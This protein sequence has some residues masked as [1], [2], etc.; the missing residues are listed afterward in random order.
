MSA[1]ALSDPLDAARAVLRSGDAQAA[2]SLLET[3][4]AEP[5]LAATVHHAEVSIELG[6]ILEQAGDY[7]EAMARFVQGHDIA[8]RHDHPAL[9]AR[10]LRGMA[11]VDHAM[12]DLQHAL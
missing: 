5:D 6:D 11:R 12:G 4:L 7:A 9:K 3:C 10:A 1:A 2:R 8:L